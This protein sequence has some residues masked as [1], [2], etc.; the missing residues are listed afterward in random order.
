M[1]NDKIF[2]RDLVNIILKYFW[3]MAI[4]VVLCLAFSITLT[5]VMKKKYQADFEINVYSKYFQNPLISGIIP[6]VYNVPEMRFTIDSMV[7]EAISDEFIDK[8]GTEIGRA[9]C[10][11]RVYDRV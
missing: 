10:R 8:I 5:Q 7:K 3:K 11:E 4:I 2:I 9:S 1:N 6:S